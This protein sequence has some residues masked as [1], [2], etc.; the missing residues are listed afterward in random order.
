[1]Q[2]FLSAK[3]IIEE[4]KNKKTKIDINK[5]HT[6]TFKIML[7]YRDSYYKEKV[8]EFLSRKVLVNLSEEIKSKIREELLTPIKVGDIE[9]SNFMEETSRRISQTF[10]TIS[11]NIAELC[12]EEELIDIG[13]K[14]GINYQKRVEHTDFIIYYPN[15]SNYSKKHRIEVKNVALRE[16]GTR[17]F[18]FDGDS[19]LGFFN[20]PAE[21][22]DNNIDIIDKNCKKTGGYCYIPPDVLEKIKLKVKGKRFKSNLEFSSDIGKFI[23]TGSF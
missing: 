11:G 8:N 18:A 3:E 22:T 5:L 17:G 15:F 19:M 1:M 16:R 21:F 14:K 10:Q 2:K 12:V 9:Y 23:K 7:E 4:A 13:L 6:L 20:E